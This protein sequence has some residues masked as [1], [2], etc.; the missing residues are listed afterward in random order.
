MKGQWLWV[1]SSVE[2]GVVKREEVFVFVV[3]T[4]ECVR[5]TLGEIPYVAKS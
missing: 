4:L 1:P 2:I 3:E 5:L